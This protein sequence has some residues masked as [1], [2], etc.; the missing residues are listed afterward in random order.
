MS[1]EKID[2]ATIKGADR[3]GSNIMV[4]PSAGH[5]PAPRRSA[6]SKKKWL[7]DHAGERADAAG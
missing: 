6:A 5:C 3:I 4:G 7:T 2:I 1:L